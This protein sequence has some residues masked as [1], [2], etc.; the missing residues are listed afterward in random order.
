MVKYKKEA[1]TWFNK[2]QSLI[3]LDQDEIAMGKNPRVKINKSVLEWALERSGR[4]SYIKEKNPK[5]SEWLTG[6][7]MPT[8]KQLESLAKKTYTPLGYFF[9]SKPPEEELPAP[10]FRTLNHEPERHSPELIDTIQTMKRRQA[11]ISEYLGKQGLSRLPFVRSEDYTKDPLFVARQI[12]NTLGLKDDWAATQQNWTK[13]L[14]KLVERIEKIGIIV[15]INGIV[16]NNTRRKLDPTE[17]RGFVLVDDFAP[18]IFIN[19]ADGKAAQMF[20]LAH[21]LAHIWFGAN[22]IFDLRYLQP[23]EDEIEQACNRVAAEFLV[24]GNEL[25]RI[26]P[27]ASKE[28]EPFQAIAR[29]FKVSELVAARRALDLGFISKNSFYD[30]YHEYL[31]KERSTPKQERGNF[32]SN[33]NYRIGRYFTETVIRAVK[34]DKLLYSEAYQLTGLYGKTFHNYVAMLETQE[35]PR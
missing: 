1:Y 9:L 18:L 19:G 21:E 10:Y 31:K 20:T 8:L 13:A 28:P 15:V 24:P 4:A 22:A 33:Q 7:S 12:K 23:A 14:S 29:Q 16:G 25:H 3:K 2:I 17:F 26:W 34:E 11:W 5:I 35:D 27:Y 6:E 32:Y 30:F